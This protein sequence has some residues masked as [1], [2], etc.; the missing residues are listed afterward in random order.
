MRRLV[1]SNLR[2]VVSVAS[3]Y[4]NRG[5]SL[6]DLI[7]EGNT[8]LMRAAEKFDYRR[9]YKFSTYAT[10]WIRQAV[11]RSIADQ[12]RTIRIPVHMAEFGRRYLQTSRRLL[13]E[14]G[15]E[16]TPEEMARAMRVPLTKINETR[17]ML[18]QQPISL[19]TPLKQDEEWRLEEVIRDVA[20]PS[21]EEEAGKRMLREE[22]RE[23]LAS[24]SERERR[25]L[26]LR[27]GLVDGRE[28]T[29]EEVGTELGVTRERARQIQAKALRQLRDTA[30]RRLIGYLD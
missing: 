10:W 24:L 9:G 18:I 5:M 19:E 28:R 16:P 3:K 13:S 27:Y 15:R 6:L 2:L 25:V 14:L 7:Q 4:T 29:L 20:A 22:V 21:P 26:E 17:R 12:S 1:E 8:G 23:A 30:H 11:T